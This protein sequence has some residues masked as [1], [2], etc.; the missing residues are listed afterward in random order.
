MFN[1]SIALNVPPDQEVLALHEALDDLEQ[2][3]PLKAQIVQLRY[4]AGMEA[5]EAAE[6]LGI[7]ER[8]LH[9]HWRFIKAWMKNRLEEK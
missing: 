5:A 9:R 7:S 6:V 2:L 1:D 4:F 3:D 8:T